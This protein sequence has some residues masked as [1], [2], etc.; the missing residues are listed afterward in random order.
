[1]S[2]KQREWNW[3]E[4]AYKRD[5][6]LSAPVATYIFNNGNRVFYKPK[7]RMG[8]YGNRKSR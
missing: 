7:K 1:M 4:E 3:S 8:T 2:E 5:P 6:E